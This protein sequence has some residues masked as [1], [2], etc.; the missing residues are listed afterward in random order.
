MSCFRSE[1]TLESLVGGVNGL[2]AGS[3]ESLFLFI[4]VKFNDLFD[5]VAAAD[6]GNTDAEVLFAIFAVEEARAADELLLVAENGS[7]H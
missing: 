2:C 3:E 6:G 7:Y 4:E 5:T 1:G